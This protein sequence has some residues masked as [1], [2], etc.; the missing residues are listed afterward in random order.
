[1]LL[2]EPALLVALPALLVALPALLV[3]LPAPEFLLNPAFLFNPVLKTINFFYFLQVICF[4]A[5][6]FVF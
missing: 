1:V 3:A 5:V 2:V 6:V 4:I